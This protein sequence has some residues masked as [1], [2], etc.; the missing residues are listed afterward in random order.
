[1]K[2][3]KLFETTAE[4]NAAVIKTPY[5]IYTKE[6]DTIEVLDEQ[7]IE[8][9]TNRPLMSLMYSKGFAANANYMTLEECAAVTSDQFDALTSAD[10]KNI[11]TFNEFKY[12]TGII[13][14]PLYAQFNSSVSLEEIHFPS[15]I[16]MFKEVS[17]DTTNRIVFSL[18]PQL[19]KVVF[20]DNFKTWNTKGTLFNGCPK[21]K[22]IDFSNTKLAY[23]ENKVSTGTDLNSLSLP[24]TIQ[25][26]HGTPVTFKTSGAKY[27]WL[28]FLMEDAIDVGQTSR[29]GSTTRIY[30]PDSSVDTYKE[31]ETY[32]SF[33]DQIYPV[34]QWQTD[35]DN[36]IITNS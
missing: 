13:N 33:A 5:L 28:K 23:L 22:N 17:Y 19:R 2:H 30:V 27:G 11:V 26:Y 20:P 12:F 29:I 32:S 1:M 18:C 25:G 34:S 9:I 24:A 8:R 6:N 4:R 7:P 3:I 31:S 14:L 36:G 21:M 10:V 15:Q 16:T 35:I